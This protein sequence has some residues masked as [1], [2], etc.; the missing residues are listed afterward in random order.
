LE[1][2]GL[3]ERLSSVG[4]TGGQTVVWVD[5]MRLG[6][7]GQVR[8]RWTPRGVKLRLKVEVRYVWRYLALAVEP[9]GRLRWAWLERFRKE[10]VAEVLG[11]WKGDG[12]G[13]V[14]W[15]NAPSHLAKLVRAV[16]VPL[17]ALPPYAPELNPAERL[18]EEIRR[19]VE[20]EVYGE[21]ERKVAAVEQVL[22]RLAADPARVRQ[23]AAWDWITQSLAQLPT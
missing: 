19:T 13:A 22:A 16:G 15:D 10:P 20:G 12:V 4:I 17:V 2:G 7:H 3:A 1:K 5:E 21:V 14:V 11:R 6:L 8:R 9:S 18:F 23:L